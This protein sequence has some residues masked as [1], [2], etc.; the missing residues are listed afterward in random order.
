MA[1]QP[2]LI[3]SEGG[4]ASTSY[5]VLSLHVHVLFSAAYSVVS[6]SDFARRAGAEVLE[7]TGSGIVWDRYGARRSQKMNNRYVTHEETTHGPYMTP[8]QT[9]G[10]SAALGLPRK[11]SKRGSCGG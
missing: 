3:V 4:Y 6:I 2:P 7:G 9:R 8:A 11:A 5:P 10:L 1:Y